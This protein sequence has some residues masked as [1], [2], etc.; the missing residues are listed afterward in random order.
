MAIPSLSHRSASRGFLLSL[1]ALAAP[2]LASADGGGVTF[3][4][5]V[6]QGQ[7]GIDYARAPSAS[8]AVMDALRQGS[9]TA[10]VDPAVVPTLPYNSNGQP[11]IAIF[12]HDLDG[13]LDLY[14]T[15]GP[16]AANSLYS[17]QLQETGSLRFVD[18]ALEAGVDA[19]GQDSSGVCFGDTDND[20]DEDLLVLGL[21]EPNRFFENLGDGTF[22]ER[23]TSALAAGDEA[24]ASCAFGDIDADGLLDVVIGNA[25]N[26]ESLIPCLV[27]PFGLT[28]HNQLFRNRGGN[29]FDEVSGTSGI[30]DL[31]GFVPETPGGAGITW[32][33]AMVDVDLD[34]DLDVVFGD[35]QCGLLEPVYGGVADRGFLHILINDGAGQFT[36]RPMLDGPYPSSSWMGLGA[37]DL[38][39]DG[40]LDLFGSNFGDYMDLATNQAYFFGQQ[41][42]RPVF[43]RGDGEFEDRG[44]GGIGASVFGWGNGVFDYDNDGDQDVIY[45]GGL[46]FAIMVPAD[47][48]GALLQNQGCTGEFTYDAGAIE[49]DHRRRVVQGL[50][51]GDLDGNG[52][53]DM[54][55]VSSFDLDESVPLVL[56]SG[57]WGSDFDSTATLGVTWDFTPEGLV[58]RGV[59][60]LPGSLAVEMSSGDNGNRSATIRAIGSVGLTA[61]GRVNRSGIGAVLRFTP[62]GGQTVLAPVEGGSSFAS[63]HALEKTFGM[64]SARFGSLDILWPGGTRNRLEGVK[65]GERL[66]VPEI[67]CSYD[68]DWPSGRDFRRC[69]KRSLTDLVREDVIDRR[70]AF[71]LF[72]SMQWAYWQAR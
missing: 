47:N 20:G 56:G 37:G 46:D 68:A 29:A 22:A 66:F 28:Q 13:D 49:K 58:W 44:V 50:A 1:A 25:F 8:I 2:I 4:D 55:S 57:S 54:V 43:G 23:T 40:T 3:T 30:Q 26:H 39:C 72:L 12:D 11:G 32:A 33:V 19:T 71:R 15:N 70:L 21:D 41:A 38:D 51:L 16:G 61:E 48:P 6:E 5:L 27:E 65:A 59:E 60:R 10:P 62:K 7:I 31:T 45:Q 36:D 64:A 69:V 35:D 9:L 17:N 52:F 63:Q 53:V 34:G 24:S 67:P 18:R 14:V 42:T